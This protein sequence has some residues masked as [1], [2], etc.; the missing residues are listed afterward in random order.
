MPKEKDKNKMPPV[1]TEYQRIIK[2]ALEDV[3]GIEV[4][5]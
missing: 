3:K 5:G 2:S 1:L 4:S